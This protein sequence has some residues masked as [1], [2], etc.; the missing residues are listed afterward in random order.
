MQRGRKAR[1]DRLIRLAGEGDDASVER[2]RVLLARA[3]IGAAVRWSLAHQG[4]D[5]ARAPALLVADEAAAELAASGHPPPRFSAERPASERDLSADPLSCFDDSIGRL[6]ARYRGRAREAPDLARSSLAEL[7][8]W[9]IAGT[10]TDGV[11]PA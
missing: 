2:H 1:L 10:D 8:A 11:G 4:I 5:P 9:C 3:A 7:L 6:V